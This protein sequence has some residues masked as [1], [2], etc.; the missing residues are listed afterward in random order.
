MDA[1][2]FLRQRKRLLLGF[3]GFGLLLVIWYF[4]LHG[5]VIVNST[6]GSTITISAIN[7]PLDSQ[8]SNNGFF[9]GITTGQINIEVTTAFGASETLRDIRP[10]SITVINL[11]VAKTREVEYVTN[12]PN[13]S[14]RPSNSALRFVTNDT[15]KLVKVGSDGSFSSYPTNTNV[16]QVAWGSDSEGVATGHNGSSYQLLY[17]AN[18]TVTLV[19]LPASSVIT[20]NL[21]VVASRSKYFVIQNDK[22]YVSNKSALGFKLVTTILPNTSLVSASDDS[23][24]Y[25]Q[26]GGT[27]AKLYVYTIGTKRTKELQLT[28][29]ETPETVSSAAISPDGTRLIVSDSGVSTVYDMEL[30]RQFVLPKNAIGQASWKSN[31]TILYVGERYIWQYDLSSHQSNAVGIAP[32]FV[33]VLHMYPDSSGKYLYLDGLSGTYMATFRLPLNES[34]LGSVAAAYLGESNITELRSGC[35]VNYVNFVKVTLVLTGQFADLNSCRSAVSNYLSAIGVDQ[36][37][38]TLQRY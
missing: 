27:R 11:P 2:F 18:D 19:G 17:V 25:Q 33:K 30:N 8:K 16:Y 21:S 26:V 10:F 3:G 36:T 29:S 32:N 31:D 13:S 23:V 38:I 15:N 6:D 1:E 20:T 12:L 35:D 22:L 7:N 14:F 9:G 5:L 24:I 28:F 34:R 37:T 4:A